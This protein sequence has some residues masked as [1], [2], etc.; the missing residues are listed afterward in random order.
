MRAFP[1]DW[2]PCHMMNEYYNSSLIYY[3]ILISLSAEEH[4][5]EYQGDFSD[6]EL[7]EN[8]N[9]QQQKKERNSTTAFSE[10]LVNS[11]KV[12]LGAN[13]KLDSSDEASS[14]DEWTDSE[15]SLS[16][17]ESNLSM[18]DLLAKYGFEYKSLFTVSTRKLDN[19]TLVR[20][21][22]PLIASLFENVPPVIHFVTVDD[23]S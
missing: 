7:E 10:R 17:E 16:S 23:K 8:L 13:S 21:K 1:N 12:S 5:D 19:G 15:T 18:S 2:L 6:D 22:P 3:N 20:L 9:V 4:E 14:E 11:S